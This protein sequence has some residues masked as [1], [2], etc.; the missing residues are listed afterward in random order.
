[1][2]FINPTLTLKRLES[3]RITTKAVAAAH[4]LKNHRYS[5]PALT[6][7]KRFKKTADSIGSHSTCATYLAIFA[8]SAGG[9]IQRVQFVSHCRL[10]LTNWTECKFLSGQFA[11]RLHWNVYLAEKVSLACVPRG[12]LFQLG[13]IFYAAKFFDFSFGNCENM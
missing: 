13:L 1:M 9:W 6:R 11:G 3:F 7:G 2:Y 12:T 8:L 10:L 5:G 4:S